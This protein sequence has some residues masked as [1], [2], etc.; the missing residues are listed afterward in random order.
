MV[1]FFGARSRQNTRAIVSEPG[2]SHRRKPIPSS[3]RINAGSAAARRSR[4]PGRS[5]GPGRR[6]GVWAYF[7]PPGRFLLLEA[8]RRERPGGLADGPLDRMEPVA[9]V[10]DV[11]RPQVLARRQEVLDPARDQGTERDL[12][13]QRAD[14]DVVIAAGAGMQ[15]DPIAAD[16]DAVGERLGLD[17]LRFKACRRLSVPTCCSRTVNSA[18]I[19][20]DSRI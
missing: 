17:V 18:S 3:Q 7:G 2:R 6:P 20:R 8:E 5:V 1:G 11:G 15:V 10:G 19:R 4:R 9:A 12:E 16:A 14:V 13:R